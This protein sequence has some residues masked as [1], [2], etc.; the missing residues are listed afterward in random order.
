[1]TGRWFP[2]YDQLRLS[3]RDPDDVGCRVAGPRRGASCFSQ[4][5]TAFSQ[6]WTASPRSRLGVADQSVCLTLEFDVLLSSVILTRLCP[7]A[8]LV[9]SRDQAWITPGEGRIICDVGG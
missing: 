4:V 1:M 7:D 2:H 8:E 3:E 6:V 5:R 9:R